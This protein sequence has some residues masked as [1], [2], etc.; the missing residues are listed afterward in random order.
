MQPQWMA[1][2]VRRNE[3]SD[4]KYDRVNGATQSDLTASLNPYF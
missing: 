2:E 3:S 4:E 1:P